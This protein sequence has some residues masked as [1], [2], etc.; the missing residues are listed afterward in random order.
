MSTQS[1]AFRRLASVIVMALFASGV[2]ASPSATIDTTGLDLAR[3][4]DAQML[5]ARIRTAAISVCRADAAPWDGKRVQH[6]RLCVEQAIKDVV[7]RVNHPVLTNLHRS[8][9]ERV[10]ER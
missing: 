1:K 2:A 4:S 6:R 8:L 10:A 3:A 7:V 5:Y 9:N